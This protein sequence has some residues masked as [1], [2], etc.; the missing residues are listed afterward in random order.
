MSIK[1]KK[2]KIRNYFFLKIR[3]KTNQ[4]KM[5]IM[6]KIFLL[7]KKK[8]KKDIPKIMEWYKH[9]SRAMELKQKMAIADYKCVKVITQIK[10][11]SNQSYKV[12]KMKSRLARKRERF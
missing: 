5:L 2:M 3:N 12:I 1:H 4:Q 6:I 10:Q 8:S 9:R 7:E 11:M